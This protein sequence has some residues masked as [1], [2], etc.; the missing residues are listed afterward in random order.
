MVKS[1]SCSARGLFLLFPPTVISQ[2]ES[3]QKREGKKTVVVRRGGEE[4]GGNICCFLQRSGRGP[5]SPLPPISPPHVTAEGRKV[6]EY[7]PSPFSPSPN[8][9][10]KDV[11]AKL[12]GCTTS[13]FP[14]QASMFIFDARKWP[15]PPLPFI[16]CQPGAF[17]GL[18]QRAN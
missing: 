9:A 18:C 3:D 5:P 8:A 7:F 6:R 4:E 14:P 11:C 13:P 1:C 17:D 2:K 15:S 16:L 12:A 10:A